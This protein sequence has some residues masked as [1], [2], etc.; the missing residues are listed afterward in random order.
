MAGI[1]SSLSSQFTLPAEKA[2]I[3]VPGVLQDVG[4]ANSRVYTRSQV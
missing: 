2:F 3:D 4:D 1:N